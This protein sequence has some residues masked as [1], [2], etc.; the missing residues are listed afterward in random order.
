MGVRHFAIIA[1]TISVAA[2]AGVPKDG[3]S[4][5]GAAIAVPAATG[6]VQSIREIKT[7][8]TLG[9][10]IGTVGGAAIGGAAGANIG[11]GTGTIIASSVL[12]VITGSV[13]ASVG[14][15]FGTKTRYEVIVRHDDGIDRAYAAENVTGIKPGNTVGIDG[16]GRLSPVGAP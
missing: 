2:C 4:G 9:A 11:G 10:L 14:R 5:S 12:S 13:G 15:P 3:A 8:G 6:T 16:S 7:P 1:L